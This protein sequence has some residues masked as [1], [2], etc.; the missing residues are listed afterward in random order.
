[1]Q[2]LIFGFAMSKIKVIYNKIKQ[3]WFMFLCKSMQI[4]LI[5]DAHRVC[6]IF[7]FGSSYLS[8]FYAQPYII[9]YFSTSY[10]RIAA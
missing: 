1:M 10:A 4:L 3:K 5:L 6:V 7:N 9:Y 2:I 8:Q